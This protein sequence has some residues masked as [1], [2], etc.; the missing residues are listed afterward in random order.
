MPLEGVPQAV[1]VHDWYVHAGFQMLGMGIAICLT[2]TSLKS[3]SNLKLHR[4]LIITQKLA[5]HL[6]HRPRQALRRQPGL[7]SG[8]IEADETYMGGKQ[9]S[10]PKARHAR[11]TIL[12]V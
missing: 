4:E 8:P 9:A 12:P 10:I 3:V 11:P 7:L 5:W 1:L 2:L 6:A